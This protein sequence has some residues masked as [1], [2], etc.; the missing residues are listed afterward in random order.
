MSTGT[1]STDTAALRERQTK[2]EIRLGTLK[3]QLH[4]TLVELLE[5]DR[6][7]GYERDLHPAGSSTGAVGGL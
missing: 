2:L 5:V 3:Y 4:Q 7:L 6:K 1:D